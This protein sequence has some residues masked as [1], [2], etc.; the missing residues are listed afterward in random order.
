[1]HVQTVIGALAN[2]GDLIFDQPLADADPVAEIAAQ[3]QVR[4][5]RQQPAGDPGIEE[6]PAPVRFVGDGDSAL[7]FE[8]ERALEKTSAFL[9]ER[10]P[11]RCG[12]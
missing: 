4:K 3:F 2:D 9:P 11:A 1:M 7:G 10:R 5:T 8:L 6:N 12:R